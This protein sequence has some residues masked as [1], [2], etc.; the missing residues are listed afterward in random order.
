MKKLQ[1]R[2][3]MYLEKRGVFSELFQIIVDIL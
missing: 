3:D 2:V 1:P